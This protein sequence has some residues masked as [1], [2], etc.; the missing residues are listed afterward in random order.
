MTDL[1]S[2]SYLLMP[3]IGCFGKIT[4]GSPEVH[5][6]SV[7]LRVEAAEMILQV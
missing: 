7:G 3:A 6:W 2:D 4:N 1:E 5:D